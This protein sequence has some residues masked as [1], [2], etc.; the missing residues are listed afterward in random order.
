MSNYRPKSVLVTILDTQVKRLRSAGLFTGDIGDLR[1]RIPKFVSVS[2]GS[3]HEILLIIPFAVVPFAAQFAMIKLDGSNKDVEVPPFGELISDLCPELPKKP[4]LITDV[5]D[6]SST[7]KANAEDCER[8]MK[9]LGRSV[10]TVNHSLA[11]LELHPESIY[12]HNLQCAGS[13]VREGDGR[14]RVPGL[15]T[16]ADRLKMMLGETDEEDPHWGMLTYKS[17]IA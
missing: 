7:L 15:F 3:N 13:R 12:R 2:S 8:N 11:L 9:A 4:Y 5:N 10:G 6:G 14:V 1:E 16:F 17:V